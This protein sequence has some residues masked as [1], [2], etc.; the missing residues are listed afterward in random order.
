[1][2]CRDGAIFFCMLFIVAGICFG[3]DDQPSRVAQA[4]TIPQE[5]QDVA[6]LKAHSGAAEIGEASRKLE[7]D[8]RATLKTLQQQWDVLAKQLQEKTQEIQKQL[9]QQWQDFNR[10]FQKS[11]QS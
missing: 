11:S 2:K 9:H 8:A 10:S 4:G 3:T 7:T 5:W 6:D 1:M